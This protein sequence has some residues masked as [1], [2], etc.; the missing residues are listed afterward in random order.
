[1]R[2]R[3]AR[4]PELTDRLKLLEFTDSPAE[5]T[6]IE[7]SVPRPAGARGA[8]FQFQG[9]RTYPAVSLSPG[10]RGSYPADRRETGSCIKCI[11]GLTPGNEGFGHLFQFFS[12]C[13][14]PRDRQPPEYAAQPDHVI[15]CDPARLLKRAGRRSC[16]G[17][18]GARRSRSGEACLSEETT[19]RECLIGTPRVVFAFERPQPVP[20]LQYGVCRVPKGYRRGPVGDANH[21]PRLQ[22]PSKLL[23]GGERG[24]KMLE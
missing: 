18:E 12:R 1:H 22:H 23:E 2:G 10:A 20:R 13:P 4:R 19:Q 8:S 5:Q 16:F 17:G 7:L 14:A 15:L 6:P 24:G 3:R 11:G 9:R 21:S